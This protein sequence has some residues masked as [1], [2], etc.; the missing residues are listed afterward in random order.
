MA[1]LAV[2]IAEILGGGEKPGGGGTVIPPSGPIIS[3]DP[4]GPP[5]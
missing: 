2:S 3:P 4:D 5:P 1:I